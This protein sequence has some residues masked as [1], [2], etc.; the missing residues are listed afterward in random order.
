MPPQRRKNEDRAH[1]LAEQIRQYWRERG[2]AVSLKVSP[3]R[4]LPPN[5]EGVPFAITSDLVNGLPRGYSGSISDLIPV[6]APP[7]PPNRSKVR[8][9]ITCGRSFESSGPGH[10]MCVDCRDRINGP[11]R[12]IG[13]V[14]VR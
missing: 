12:N 1:A 3:V 7:E 9:C 11:D 8:P 10:R 6:T 5:N 4:G 13:R 14:R 2:Y